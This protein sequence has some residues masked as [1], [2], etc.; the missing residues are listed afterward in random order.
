MSINDI[1][2][3]KAKIPKAEDFVSK[4]LQDGKKKLELL[5]YKTLSDEAQLQTYLIKPFYEISEP[6]QFLAY[7]QSH[8]KVKYFETKEKV[9]EDLIR[10]SSLLIYQNQV[11]L[12]DV[13]LE[14]NNAV[15][16][17]SAETTIL[18]PKSG[19]SESLPINIGLI[20]QRYPEETLM[21]E[22][23]NI[24]SISK[25]TVNLLYDSKKVDKA[26]LKEVK[27]FLSAIEIE[28][29]QSGEQL[30]D[31][32]KKSQRV[33][34]PTLMVTERP[35]RTVLNIA[36]GKI[37]LL[38]SGS[39]FA[40]LMPSVLKDQMASMA[41]IYHTY[42]IGKFLLLVR[43]IGLFTTITLPALYVALVSYNPEVFRVQL[44]LSV[45]GSRH[46]VPY[47]SFVEVILML[48]MMELLMEASIR[49]PKAIGP[50]AT[51]VG[52][53]IL[54]Q[55]ATEA[56]LVS[57]IMIII[58]SLGAIANFVIP[59]STFSFAIR[60]SKYFILLLSIFYGLVGVIL[61]LF[62][63]LAYMVSLD[64]FGKPYLTFREE[65]I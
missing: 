2:E 14:K 45:A 47:P 21:I 46:A 15:S 1:K 12:L 28:M 36:A 35:D 62:L 29:F 55:A 44:A 32:T 6:V 53:L 5:Y 49:L 65:K 52:G 59:I 64:S 39:P 38:V 31:F 57:T 63:L 27:T 17:T 23:T 19:F 8:P 20:R 18:G 48:I 3:L 56:G 34:F 60:V 25:T 26:V 37:T 50:T 13:K 11:F 10:G 54:G 41:D 43:Y 7:L 40:V 58:V 24:G 42:W 30:L 51:T 61:G 33:L 16:E 4:E 9:Q 22:S